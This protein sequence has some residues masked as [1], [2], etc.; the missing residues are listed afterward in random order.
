[1]TII[2]IQGNARNTIGYGNQIPVTLTL[3][4]KTGNVL[5]AA[6]CQGSC[7]QGSAPQVSSISQYGVTWNP[8]CSAESDNVP[9]SQRVEIWAG[10]VGSDASTAIVVNLNAIQNREGIVD[11]CEYAGL[12]TN[13]LLDKTYSNSGVSQNP[14]TGTTPPTSQKGQLWIGATLQQY[15]QQLPPATNGFTLL[16]GLGGVYSL[17]YLEKIV[18]DI[19][20]A[21]SGTSGNWNGPWDGCIA[22]FNAAPGLRVKTGNGPVDL[23]VLGNGFGQT[24]MGGIPKISCAGQIFD[25][26]LVETTDQTASPVRIGTSNGTK[27]IQCE[28][29][30]E[31]AGI[32]HIM[33]ATG[34]TTDPSAG[35]YNYDKGTNVPVTATPLPGYTFSQWILD[36]VYVGSN[37]PITVTMNGPHILQPTF[38]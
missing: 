30:P 13:S 24:G 28:P 8:C 3:V 29:Q 38:Y 31:T 17:A 5:I 22:T 27:A 21:N 2:R 4:P 33:S 10:V 19:G 6:I 34:G 23:N 16:D 36:Y 12:N 32:L 11:V 26:T 7:G 35:M 14:D 15:V 1:M 37:N 20:T 9:C 25:L 18:S